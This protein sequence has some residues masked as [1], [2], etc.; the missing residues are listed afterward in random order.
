MKNYVHR[1]LAELIESDV[2]TYTLPYQTRL[3]SR[4]AQRS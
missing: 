2:F 4:S 3:E 1:I